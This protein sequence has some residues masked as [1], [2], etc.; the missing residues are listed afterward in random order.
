MRG[1]R[2]KLS[3]EA[4]LAIAQVTRVMRL[5]WTSLWLLL[6]GTAFWNGLIC[7]S[8]AEDHR[9]VHGK[10]SDCRHD[11]HI[12]SIDD[13]LAFVKMETARSWFRKKIAWL[14]IVGT[15]RGYCAFQGLL[16]V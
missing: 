1:S 6:S 10:E 3:V 14:Q 11:C 15:R 12:D 7:R 4:I 5:E 8:K 9:V 2:D 16:L 13:G